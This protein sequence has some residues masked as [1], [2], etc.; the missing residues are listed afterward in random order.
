MKTGRR[1]GDQPTNRP[2]D[3]SYACQKLR[4]LD[5]PRHYLQLF[6]EVVDEVDAYVGS[7]DNQEGRRQALTGLL[8]VD[9]F[10]EILLEL[11]LASIKT[12]IFKKHHKK[13][14]LHFEDFEQLIKSSYIVHVT[15][16]LFFDTYIIN[17]MYLCILLLLKATR[18]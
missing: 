15:W 12:F 10:V 2:T 17:H 9:Q 3:G 5:T 1:P 14:F 8:K 4:Y 16:I 11:I 6:G 18:I 7:P 13:N